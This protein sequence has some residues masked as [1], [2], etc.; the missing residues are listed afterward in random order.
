MRPPSK[1]LAS[2]W[3]PV[4]PACDGDAIVVAPHPDDEVLGAGIILRW[5]LE[6]GHA[7]TVIACTDGEASHARSDA[8]RPDELRRRR[9]DE[10]S[11]AFETLG[12]DPL[13]DS[14]GLPDGR[15]ASHAVRLADE[16]SRRCNRDTTLIVP[17]KHDGH[18]DHRAVHAAGA[19][20][21][22]RTG[23]TVWQI[24]IWGKVRRD[25]PFDGR[26]HC[27]ELCPEDRAVK[28][29]AVSAFVTQTSPVGP[30]RYD[31]PVLHADELECMLDG[32]EVVL[33]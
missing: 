26:V 5:L 21:A 17:W 18:P 15:L 25:R 11:T 8:I 19:R 9:R 30:G 1:R 32:V 31:G 22:R 33:R 27:L 2:R 13:V 3:T 23:A 16:L 10:R 7:V 20:A 29:R 12:I 4:A 14:L 6:R 28:D 24:P